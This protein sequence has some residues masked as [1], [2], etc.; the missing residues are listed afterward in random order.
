MNETTN[1]RTRPFSGYHIRSTAEPDAEL[2]RVGP[3]T[4]CGEYMRRF[5]H[6]IAMTAELGDTPKPV[7]V[8]GEELVLFRDLSGR[9]GLLHKHCAHRH[10][11]LEYG[12]VAE[13]GIRCC[14]HGWLY[15]ID[16]RIL[17]TPGEPATSRIKD[18][19]CLG[20]YPA[21]DYKGLIFAYMGP[22]DQAPEFPVFDTFELPDNELV[23]YA[24]D[25]PCNWLQV[26]EN[27][28]DPFHSVFLH[29][30]VTRAHF[31]PA[32]GAMPIVEWVPMASKAGIY[33]TNTRRWQQYLWIR[34]AEVF[35]PNFAQPPDIYQNPDRE[36]FFPRVGISKWT[37]PTADAS[38][39]IVG[40]RHFN[41]TLDLDGKGDRSKVGLNKIDFVGQTGVERSYEEGQRMPGDYEAQ[42][43][44]GPITVHALETLGKTDTGVAMYRRM[45]RRS[46]RAVAAGE[47]LPKPEKNA[48][49]LVASMAGDV[50]VAHPIS[51]ADDEAVQ[52]EMGHKV[53]EVVASTL[54]I[55]HG[56]RQREIESG[57]RA[58]LA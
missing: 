32:W 18:N 40:W 41:E 1:P 51:N 52:R 6:P 20:A 46:I 3:G 8:L 31:N 37:V 35:L 47:A 15:D 11:S 39:R 21:R 44:Q 23:P 53:G 55:S 16:G 22:P 24:I 13:R 12:I 17:E 14:Y 7:T 58:L 49:G 56:D 48:D 33:L 42:I 30:R 28:M 29:T 43:S 4:P 36:K 54:K 38:C 50:I 26:A 9:I 5:W 10:T 27:P 25:Y 2:T 45:L 57:V 34:T 19:L